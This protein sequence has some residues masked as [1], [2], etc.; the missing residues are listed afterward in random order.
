MFESST[1]EIDLQPVSC[2]Y[3]LS[4]SF[5]L[6]TQWGVLFLETLKGSP[7]IMPS[8]VSTRGYFVSKNTG[9]PSIIHDLSISCIVRSFRKSAIHVVNKSP[10]PSEIEKNEQTKTAAQKRKES[11]DQRQS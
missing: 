7:S 8:N 3:R 6:T 11:D 10:F 5:S 2:R 1:T 9:V 4:M